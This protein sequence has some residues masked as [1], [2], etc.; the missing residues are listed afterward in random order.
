V[1]CLTLPSANTVSDACP[2]GGTLYTRDTLSMSVTS[3]HTR[4]LFR[5]LFSRRNPCRADQPH[6]GSG[7]TRNGCLYSRPSN[8]KET[9]CCILCQGFSQSHHM[10]FLRWLTSPV[11]MPGCIIDTL[12]SLSKMR[13][14]AIPSI[15]TEIVGAPNSSRTETENFLTALSGVA[16]WKEVSS[17]APLTSFPDSKFLS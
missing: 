1:G 17:F 13:R 2:T 8:V 3:Y 6:V 4:N 16:R 15:S 11:D 12:E 14:L 9:N 7:H 10:V 5:Q